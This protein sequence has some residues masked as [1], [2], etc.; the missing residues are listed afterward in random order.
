MPLFCRRFLP[1]K[2]ELFFP[3]FSQLL[4]HRGLTDR[5]DFLSNFAGSLSYNIKYLEANVVENMYVK[6]NQFN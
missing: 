3:T 4:A 2:R 1:L 6:L 5:W